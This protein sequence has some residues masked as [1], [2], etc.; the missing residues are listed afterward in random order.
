MEGSFQCGWGGG[1]S[2]K[3]DK[4]VYLLKFWHK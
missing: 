4:S 1:V 3:V 2:E